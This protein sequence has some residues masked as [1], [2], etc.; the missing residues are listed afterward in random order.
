MRTDE[1]EYGRVVT[2]VGGAPGT[3]RGNEKTNKWKQENYQMEEKYI[4]MEM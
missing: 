3:G 2:L 1:A 4:K